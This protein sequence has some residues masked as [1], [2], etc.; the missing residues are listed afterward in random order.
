MK[1]FAGLIIT[2]L[3]ALGSGCA[4][5]PPDSP[6][7]QRFKINRM[8]DQAL[9]SA[10]AAYP[11]ARAAV[12]SAAGYAI[13]DVSGGK[14]LYGGMDHGEGV[15]VN[16][17]TQ[18]HTYMKMF[19]LQPG[20]GFGFS[21]SRLVFIFKTKAAFQDFITSGWQFSTRMTA[22]A[23]NED[24]GGAA[25]LGYA[26]TPDITVYQMTEK[27]VLVGVSVTGAKYWL[28]DELN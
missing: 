1:R 28:N 12:R 24:Q 6:A 8:A 16:N 14:I 7:Q 4:S 26:I 11:R 20:F 9:S 17:T 5:T 2:L 18:K 10:Y 25:E 22:A 23:K 15:A 3:M 13:F 21:N 19:E 27:G